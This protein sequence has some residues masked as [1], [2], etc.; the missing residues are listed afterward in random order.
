MHTQQKNVRNLSILSNCLP[1]FEQGD[2]HFPQQV[3]MPMLLLNSY[4][5]NNLIF[6]YLL[7]KFSH[8]LTL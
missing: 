3:F 2:N 5:L 7:F 8:L 6:F 4:D 1:P